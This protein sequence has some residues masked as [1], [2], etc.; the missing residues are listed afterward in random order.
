MIGPRRQHKH[1]YASSVSARHTKAMIS[2]LSSLTSMGSDVRARD[3]RPWSSRRPAVSSV[4]VRG[5]HTSEHGPPRGTSAQSS[6]LR[7]TPRHAGGGGRARMTTRSLARP[8]A[9]AVVEITT[10]LANPV[11]TGRRGRAIS[12]PALKSHRAPTPVGRG[13]DRPEQPDIVAA[14]HASREDRV[15]DERFPVPRRRRSA[16]SLRQVRAGT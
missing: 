4:T 10:D 13:G 1:R 9:G 5:S 12:R 8:E 15:L 16:T 7:S 11:H 2:R 3:C 14:S 6:S